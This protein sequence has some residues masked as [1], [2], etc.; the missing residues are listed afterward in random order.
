MH[1][2]SP[3]IPLSL[4]TVVVQVQQWEVVGTHRVTGQV[5][6]NGISLRDTSQEVDV[7]LRTISADA[8]LPNLTGRNQAVTLGK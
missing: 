2:D 3:V 5:L 7:I 6:L 4:D 8:H 1:V